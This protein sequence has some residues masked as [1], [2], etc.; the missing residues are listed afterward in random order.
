LQKIVVV[1]FL[2][3]FCIIFA[4]ILRNFTNDGNKNSFVFF[5]GVQAPGWA[6][7]VVFV[8]WK[9]HEKMDY[10]FQSTKYDF[11]EKISWT[12]IHIRVEKRFLTLASHILSK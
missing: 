12:E 10:T 2:I 6:C 5:S 9:W 3:L 8:H 1:R 4:Q 11:M 7:T